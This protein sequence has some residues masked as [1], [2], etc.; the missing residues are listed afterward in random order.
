MH[1]PTAVHTEP[2]V[3]GDRPA[4]Y[5]TPEQ[6]TGPGTTL[7]VR[8]GTSVF[9]S[10]TNAMCLTANRV[11][12]TGL[13]TFSLDYRLAP[14]HPFPAA[15][16]DALAAC[17]ALLEHGV[18]RA[19]AAF[20]SDSAA[21]PPAPGPSAADTSRPDAPAGALA[22]ASRP[23]PPHPRPSAR[24]GIRRLH[25]TPHSRRL[26]LPPQTHPATARR[27]GPVVH[28]SL[29]YEQGSGTDSLLNLGAGRASA[30]GRTS[31]CRTSAASP[32]S[33]LSPAPR[34]AP[35]STHMLTSP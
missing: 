31:L 4:L 11:T 23:P 25:A 13:Q 10:P 14:E 12:R 5:V 20:A 30:A 35:N 19:T 24:T 9:G 32:A 17:R 16:E 26:L 21:V 28:L 3:L 27:T 33:S 34:R 1:V 2:A 15:V 6:G 8:G 7:Y 29:P 18:D 22:A